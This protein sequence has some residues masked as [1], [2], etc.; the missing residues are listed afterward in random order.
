MLRSAKLWN[1]L[2]SNFSR[3]QMLEYTMAGGG[4]RKGVSVE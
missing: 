4:A 3:M 2:A 1:L